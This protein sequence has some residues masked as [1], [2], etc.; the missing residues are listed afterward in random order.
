MFTNPTLTI[1]LSQKPKRAERTHRYDK[2]HKVRRLR[3]KSRTDSRRK[4]RR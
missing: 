3:R 1:M 2:P 4:S